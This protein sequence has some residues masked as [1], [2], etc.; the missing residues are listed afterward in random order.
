MSEG[1][2][3]DGGPVPIAMADGR[4]LEALLSCACLELRAWPGAVPQA[5]RHARQVLWDAG[6]KELIEPVEA[7]VSEIVTNA[8]R[9]CGGLEVQDMSDGSAVRLWLVVADEGG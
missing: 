6:L 2:W 7:V 3:L 9:A 8:I 5:R 4:A 1:A